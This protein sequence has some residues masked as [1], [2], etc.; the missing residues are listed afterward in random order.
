MAKFEP[1]Q[2]AD[3]LA[4]QQVINEWATDLD[5]T[6]G[7]NVA[8]LLTEDCAYVVRGALRE[9]RDAVVGFYAA[10]KAEMGA[11]VEGAPIHRH[12][13]SNYRVNFKGADEASVG[14]SLI[15]FSTAGTDAGTAETKPFSYADVFMDCRRCADGHWRISRF[16]SKPV[17]VRPIK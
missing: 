13:L 9:G 4:I 14:F 3:V 17:F 1:Q 11:T 10:R 8:D 6:N 7:E 15:Y 16:D 5:I 2:A 12:A